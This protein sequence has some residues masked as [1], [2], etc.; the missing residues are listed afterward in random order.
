MKLNKTTILSVFLCGILGTSCSDYLDIEK[1]IKDRLTLEEVFSKHDYVEEWLAQ[2]YYYLGDECA[3]VGVGQWPFCFSD[4]MYS[5]DYNSLKELSYNE[6]AYQGSW[7][8]CYM[9]IRQATIFIDNIHLCDYFSEEK[10]TDF[11]GQARFVRAFFYWK[12]LQKYGPVPIIP[13]GM[14]DYTDDYIDLSL[15]RNTYDEC[16]EYI[17]SEMIQAAQELPLKRDYNSIARPTKGSALA[18]RAKALLFAASPLM[19]GNKDKYAEQLV[20]DKGNR[21]LAAEYDETKWAKAAAAAKDVMDLNTYKLYVAY[22]RVS[23]ENS[24]YPTTIKPYDDGDFSLKNWPD[25]YADIDPLESYRSLFNGELSASENPELIFTR[26]QNQ[27]DGSAVHFMV[28]NQLPLRARGNNKTCMT[29]KQV[30]AYYMWDGTDCPGM[31]SMYKNE[32]GYKGRI[33]NRERISDFVTEEDQAM[34]PELGG[35]RVG[36][37]KQYVRREPRFYASVAY[38]GAVWHFLNAS[39]VEDLGPYTCWYFRGN[40]EGRD[41]SN[42]WLRTGIGVM[43][44]IRPTDTNDDNNPWG[45][46]HITRKSDTALRYADI[47]LMYAEALNELTKSYEIPSWDGSMVHQLSRNIDEMKKA[48]RPI[49]IRA[50]VPDYS[51]DI[52]GNQQLFRTKLKRER[53]IELMGEGQRYFDLR[54]WKDA[55]VEDAV[56][57][58]GCNTMMTAT[59]SKLFHTPVESEILNYFAE[60]T[61]FWPIHRDELRKNVRLTQNPGWQS[62]Y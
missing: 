53:Q 41:N 56:P 1:D 39:K 46:S 2:A 18:V 35:N 37:S 48:I 6:E 43:K 45:S 24:A 59:E 23:D 28:L 8:N 44:F 55:N 12:L 7:Q 30:D 54:R 3:D 61:Y 17:S 62:Q 36:V 25:G 50:G 4:D 5:P 14:L 52:Y 51:S 15:P 13:D 34:Y 9:G 21:L 32:P 58:Y 31:N 38:N 20:D 26:C 47:L 42:N 29:Q 33:D 27:P 60:K 11:K 22:S 16:V 10:K 49:R 40:L 19:N 57:I